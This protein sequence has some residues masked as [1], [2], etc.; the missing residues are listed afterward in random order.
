MKIA[1]LTSMSGVP[2]GGS[3]EL[4]SATA[5]EALAAGHQVLA[6]V[7]RWPEIPRPLQ[8][9][10]ELG[11]GIDLRPRSSRIRRSALLTGLLRPFS[12]LKAFDPDVVCVSQGGTYD[13]GK[14]GEFAALWRQQRAGGWPYVILCQCEQPAPNQRVQARVR[15]VFS[16]AAAVGFL[17]ESLQRLSERDLGYPIPAGRSLQNPFNFG[18]PKRLPWPRGDC[19]KLLFVGRLEPVKGVH[20]ILEAL[21][22][23]V[24]QARDWR[25][26][27][28][29]EGSQIASLVA[30]AQAA[31]IAER[32]E[33]RGYA[34]DVL[35]LWPE[36]EVLLLP[37][38]AEGLPL[39]M[40]EAMLCA[41][42]VLATRVGC[43]A[44]WVEDGRSGFLIERPDTSALEAALERVWNQRAQLEA[45]G[46]Q[47]FDRAMQLRDPA[48]AVTLLRCLTAAATG[49]RSS[50]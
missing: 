3:E 44:D 38:E 8:R 23:P 29:G 15:G 50:E 13:V 4:W 41:R 18:E 28:A 21:S 32:V 19:L 30:Q 14:R 1:F 6:S 33:F 22:R 2:W 47:A 43:I 11:A 39:V 42:P 37:S 49:R 27:V 26:T 36:H 20:L 16:R 24:W 34:R 31:G 17:G 12:A 25:L 10:G 45:L 48:P 7:Y 46:L 35:G 9:L 40:L 5:S